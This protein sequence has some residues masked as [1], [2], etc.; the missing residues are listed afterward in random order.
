MPSAGYSRQGQSLAPRFRAYIAL[1]ARNSAGYGNAA[2]FQS[3][4]IARA[5]SS[6]TRLARS[7][8]D[9]EG[10]CRCLSACWSFNG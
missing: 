2:L 8:V 6:F 5:G 9:G 1:E 7:G 3:R 10:V 4:P